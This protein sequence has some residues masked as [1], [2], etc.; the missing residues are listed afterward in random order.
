MT[1]RIRLLRKPL[2]ALLWLLLTA[3]MSAF[4][5]VGFSLWSSTS[6]LAKSLDEN[7]VAVAV[8]SDQAMIRKAA[9]SA[10]E[11]RFFTQKDKAFLEGLDSVKAVRSHTLSAAV[12]PSL[13]PVL[14]VDRYQTYKAE[15]NPLP[16]CNAVIAGTYRERTPKAV[17]PETVM[18]VLT[19]ELKDILLIGEEYERAQA[20]D[21]LREAGTL[22]VMIP[23]SRMAEEDRGEEWRDSYGFGP[24]DWFEEGRT[25]VL[26]GYYDPGAHVF[27]YSGIDKDSLPRN[28]QVM[29]LGSLHV[30]DDMLLSYGYRYTA[31]DSFGSSTVCTIEPA[32]DYALPAAELW[33]DDPQR[34][35]EETPHDVWRTFRSAWEKQQHSLPVIGTE[36]LEAMY[37]FMA[38]R[39]RICDGRS[40][41]EEEYESGA[42]VLV[43]SRLLAEQCG[44]RPGDRIS[45]TQYRDFPGDYGELGEINDKRV[46]MRAGEYYNDPSV[47]VLNLNRDFSRPEEEFTVVGI[48]DLLS[49]WVLGPYDFGPNTV[50]MPKK[51]Q[52]DGAFGEIPDREEGPDIY[53]VL[54]SVELV[55]GRMDEFMTRLEGTDYEWQFFAYDQGVE[56]ALKNVRD[57]SASM[58]RLFLMSAFGWLLFL[59]L[60]VLMFQGAERQTLGTMRS[61][62]EPAVRTGSYLFRGGF[63]VALGGVIPGSAA[64]GFVLRF[65]RQGILR[66]ALAGLDRTMDAEALA[67]AEEKL[68]TMHNAGS[69]TAAQ[70]ILLAAVQLLILTAALL[71]HAAVLSRRHPRQL[72]EG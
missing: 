59:I 2:T 69:L 60:Y 4:L 33:E 62:G 3:L 42:K 68:V 18:I 13:R 71:I 65:V 21:R 67:A 34:F 58:E 47:D 35:F 14:N 12:F 6:R 24:V 43:I 53:G 45:L 55:N 17:G 11:E 50:F 66:D 70:L 64:G 10:P 48:Y 30:R 5:V 15:G 23:R 63:L 32:E 25:Y 46:G 36:H 52:I 44:I 16:Y 40:F 51:A 57:M 9:Y 49:A 22:T 27:D 31:L 72:M 1:V 54:L 7:A 38:D 41:T 28:G 61:L 29:F 8:R 37:A 39:A 19:F 26:A 20:A 56:G